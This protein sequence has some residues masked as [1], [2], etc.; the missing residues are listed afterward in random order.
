[1]Q[2]VELFY[3]KGITMEFIQGFNWAVPKAFND[4]ITQCRF[5]AGDTLYDTR[6]AYEKWSSALEYLQY[7]IEVKS[8]KSLTPSLKSTFENNWISPIELELTYYKR[9]NKKEVIE[10]TYGRLFTCIWRGD[11]GILRQ[12]VPHPETPL[13]LRQVTKKL[14]EVESN[15][16][17]L[18]DYG[19]TFAMAYDPTN[20]IARQK[21]SSLFNSL[22]MIGDVYI[23]EYSPARLHMSDADR[24]H[25]TISILCFT[26]NGDDIEVQNALEAALY[27]GLANPKPSRFRLRT[28][29]IYFK[30]IDKN[31]VKYI[32]QKLF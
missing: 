14:N 11:I 30:E 29:G 18:V 27:T 25:P 8:S 12:D 16:R 9:Q 17:K 24:I 19:N 21:R 23:K 13:L 20:N 1:M 5:E 2:G 31:E 26:S 6:K 10:T 28:H 4:A 32:S 22:K 7:G 3:N 15:L